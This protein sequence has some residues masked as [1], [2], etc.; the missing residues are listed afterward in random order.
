MP[1]TKFSDLIVPEIFTKYL[2]Q[3]TTKTNAFL[4]SGIA[5]SDPSVNITDGGKTVNIPFFHELSANDEVLSEGTALTVN[6]ITAS[7]D[8]AAIHARS[9]AFG[10]YDLAKLFSGADPIAAMR[11]QLGNFWSTKFTEIL[12]NTLKG[13]FGVTDLAG[14]NELDNSA[15]ALTADVMSDAMFLLGDKSAK[16]TAIAMHSKVFSKLK[17]LDLIDTVQPSS[18][19]PAY[20]SYM[21]KRIIMDDAIEPISGTGATAVYPIYLFGAGSI[22][23][24]ENGAL[25]T[26]EQDRDILEKQ[27]IFTSTRVFT[28]HPRGVKWVGTPEDG[29]TPSNTEL[30]TAANWSLVENPKNV[31]IARVLTKV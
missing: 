1:A 31:A 8:I 24:N 19:S 10:A 14:K 17:K 15:N 22:A 27:D 21:T 7:K 26:Y 23:Y 28:M 30:A 6:N 16:I 18:L 3:E 13:I 12:L 5:S 20:N 2:I 29:E 4:N 9:V 11:V 25:A